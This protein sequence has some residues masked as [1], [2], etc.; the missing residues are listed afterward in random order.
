ME[1]LRLQ[2]LLRAMCVLI[3]RYMCVSYLATYVSAY[4]LVL[5]LLRLQEAPLQVLLLTRRSLY[6]VRLQV[7]LLTLRSLYMCPYTSLYVSDTSL[8]TSC[9]LYPPRPPPPLG[10]PA[11]RAR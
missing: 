7:L 8:C 9:L 4:L 5:E 10:R 11:E 3:P 1:L 6:I 2:V